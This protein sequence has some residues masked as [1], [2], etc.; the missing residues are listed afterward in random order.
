YPSVEVRI[1]GINTY[2][3]KNKDTPIS[4]IEGTDF[5]T[6]EIDDALLFGGIDFA[7]HSAKD[8]PEKAADGLVTAA[9]TRPIDPYDVLVSRNDLRLEELP[10]G[11]RVGTSSVRRKT[12]LEKYRGDF[13]IIDMRGNIG[14]RLEKL[15]NSDIDGIVIAAAGLIRLGVTEKIT[16]RLT[17]D[18]MQTHIFQGALAIVA[19]EEDEELIS[20]LS[21]LD[22]QKI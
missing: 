4:R 9:I 3:D 12:Q 5:F 6:K 20:M 11:A 7:V 18:I 16:Q 19:R 14:E 15:Y 13:Q 22:R 10:A 21:V 2:G 1:V 8:L 17:F